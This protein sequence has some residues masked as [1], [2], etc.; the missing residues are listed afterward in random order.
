[1]NALSPA[2]LIESLDAKMREP[3]FA[4]SRERTGR[5]ERGESPLTDSEKALILYNA[6]QN[7]VD[8][9]LLTGKALLFGV[10][11]HIDPAG[12]A[13]FTQNIR[14]ITND[15]RRGVLN[16]F[17]MPSPDIPGAEPGMAVVAKGARK[18]FRKK[19][20]S[21]TRV[22]YYTKG[23]DFSKELDDLIKWAQSENEKKKG[24]LFPKVF[25]YC[26]TPDDLKRVNDFLGTLPA[27][28]QARYRD[29]IMVGNDTEGEERAI[30]DEAKVIAVGAA[31]MNDKRLADF[32]LSP[33]DL[34]ESR[35]R[36]FNFLTTN[37]IIAEDIS[38]DPAA[39]NKLLDD[40]WKGVVFLR[41][42]R[43]NW[44]SIRDWKDA[45]D[46]VLRSL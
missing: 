18:T 44:E 43:V 19:Y 1:M 40:I 17:L 25:V 41:I 45:Q 5:L 39:Y 12:N 10:Q 30:V 24:E 22:D 4:M 20:G 26:T 8:G 15:L 23:E 33:E 9:Q 13:M 32:G 6:G 38:E 36:L 46:E 35:K 3:G 42:T 31:L 16:V 28:T 11:D 2:E 14:L 37:D 21:D 7:T 27:D 34:F 29:M